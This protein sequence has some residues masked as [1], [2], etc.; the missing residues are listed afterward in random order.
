MNSMGKTFDVDISGPGIAAFLACLA[1]GFVSA[2]AASF[3]DR[4]SC[5]YRYRHLPHVFD[6]GSAAVATGRDPSFWKTTAACGAPA[7]FFI[8]PIMDTLSRFVDQRVR[9]ATV[10]AE[11]TL[12][13]GTAS[14]ST[15]MR[16]SSGSS[17]TRKNPSLK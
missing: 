11:S 5:S 6:Q 17:G 10:T 2:P 13:R 12:T 9:V 16:L 7:S 3:A 15:W 14:P 8:V 4:A 1:A